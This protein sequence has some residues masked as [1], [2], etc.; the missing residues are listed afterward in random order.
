MRY[1]TISG[2]ARK[3]K[4]V[5]SARKQISLTWLEDQGMSGGGRFQKGFT[6]IFTMVVVVRA[7]QVYTFVKTD[8]I[9]YS[10][11]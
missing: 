5:Y 11:M 8:Q 3:C 2:N 7:S 10:S 4:P 1:D 6:Y 9:I